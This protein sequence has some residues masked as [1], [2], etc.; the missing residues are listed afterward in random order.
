MEKLGFSPEDSDDIKKFIH[1]YFLPQMGVNDIFV[2]D[3]FLSESL[4]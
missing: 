2:K 4:K 3:L 1:D